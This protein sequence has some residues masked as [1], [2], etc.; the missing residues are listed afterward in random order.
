MPNIICTFSGS[1][2]S[3]LLAFAQEIIVFPGE[4]PSGRVVPD[5]PAVIKDEVVLGLGGQD[6]IEGFGVQ[7]AVFVAA[8]DVGGEGF[9]ALEEE[10]S[11][12]LP[13]E[14]GMGALLS[15]VLGADVLADFLSIYPRAFGVDVDLIQLGDDVQ[16]VSEI[17]THLDHNQVSFTFILQLEG[18]I[19]FGYEIEIFERK[20]C[21]YIELTDLAGVQD[22]VIEV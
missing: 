13:G 10:K 1:V 21:L 6:A 4:E 18:A 11:L 8:D 12:G 2:L 20:D 17:G 15:S 16:E 14:I 19:Y 3:S 22:G 9:L 7:V 5:I